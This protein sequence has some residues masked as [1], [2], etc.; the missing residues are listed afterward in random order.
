MSRLSL[1]LRAFAKA[2]DGVTAVEYAV[3]LAL[4][5]AVIAGIVFTLGQRVAGA[6]DSVDT[7]FA[8]ALSDGGSGDDGG[9]DD[10][11]GDDD[12]GDDDDGDHDD[13]DDD[14]GDDDGDND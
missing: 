11:E 4:I 8:E 12:D 7:A 6:F 3:L 14:D 2:K 1:I 13:G 5:A 10:D 9:D